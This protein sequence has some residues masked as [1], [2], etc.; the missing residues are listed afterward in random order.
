MIAGGVA[1]GA[2]AGDALATAVD[3]ITDSIH[4]NSWLNPTPTTVYQLLSNVDNSVMKYGIT[5][6]ANPMERYTQAFYQAANVR[7]DVITTFESRVPARMLEIML[8]TSYTA[9]NG[10]L[11]P[12]SGRC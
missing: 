6:E 2:A 9:A 10:K 8:C 3:K 12:M 1:L 7:M 4:G 5:N 11:P